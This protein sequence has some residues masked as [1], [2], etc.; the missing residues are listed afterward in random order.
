MAQFGGKEIEIDEYRERLCE[1]HS[2][3]HEV[4]G[5][6]VTLGVQQRHGCFTD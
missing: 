5:V 1:G 3:S 6:R 4:G 2:D